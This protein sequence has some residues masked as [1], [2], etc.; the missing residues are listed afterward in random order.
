MA[1]GTILREIREQ[2]GYTVTQVAEATHMMIQVVEELEREDFHRIAAP[3]YGRGFV[4]LYAEFL[5]IDAEPLVKEFNEIYS[6][7]RRPVVATRDVKINPEI[8]V[9]APAEAAPLSQS[10]V[11]TPPI[12]TE[13]PAPIIPRAVEVSLVVSEEPDVDCLT[14][15]KSVFSLEADPT[16]APVSAVAGALDDL[17]SRRTARDLPADSSRVGGGAEIGTG[18]QAQGDPFAQFEKE[19]PAFSVTVRARCRIVADA[20]ARGWG[21][22]SRRI[23]DSLPVGWRVGPVLMGIAAALVLITVGIIFLTR[24]TKQRTP[25][26]EQVTEVV[27]TPLHLSTVLSPPEPYVD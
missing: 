14:G 25:V 9:V 3:I 2:Q 22:L 10:A 20:L 18:A 24:G 27:A 19:T 13:A 21:Q 26:L 17:F 15:D 6:G 11:S 12:T 23:G 4:K 7:S 1:L 8:R 5:N 16:P